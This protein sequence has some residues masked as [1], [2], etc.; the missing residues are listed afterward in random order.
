VILGRRLLG[1]AI[2]VA[3]GLAFAAC[4]PSVRF[5][6]P[7]E[8]KAGTQGSAQASPAPAQ[9]ATPATPAP[10]A[11][12][13]PGATP[14]G[15]G[16]L[17]Q[18][19]DLLRNLAAQL[20]PSIVE[21]DT[22]SGTG[23]GVVYDSSGDIVTNAHVVGSATTVTVIAYDSSHYQA[24][25]VGSYPGND[26]AVVRVS[27]F[28]GLKPAT[29]GDSSKV[30]VGDIVLAIGSPYGLANTVTDGIV[31][32]TG[33]TESEGNGV[34]L[35]D[36]IQTT[37]GIN[38]GNSGGGLVDTAGEVIGMPTLGGSDRQQPGQPSE[39]IGFA[40]SSNQIV[41]VARQ[42]IA[43][44]NVTHTGRAYL[45]ITTTDDTTGG[46]R[47]TNVI[48]GGPA[49]KAGLLAGWVITNLGGQVVGDS[50]RVG[51]LLSGYKPGDRVSLTVRLPDGSNRTLNVQ[52]GERPVNP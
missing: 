20:T 25:V 43:N 49:D 37:A 47:V 27:G 29:F 26:L 36:L 21:I 4:T 41:N 2:A 34:V 24:D 30:K 7:A 5:A 52:L 17:N 11:T 35:T 15:S 13:V 14:S 8:T 18:F 12:P 23:S 3:V 42:L 50:N 38:P 10:A 40:I 16:A 32:A 9:P 19:Q 44:G 48:S 45:G 28:D 51:E 1:S 22:G 6:T 46:A 39:S 31:S 33:R